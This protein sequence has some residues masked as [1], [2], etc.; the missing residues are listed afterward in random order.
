MPQ[1]PPSAPSNIKVISFIIALSFVCALVLA[2]LAS[3]LKE[4]QEIAR[5]LDRSKQ[6]LM[7]ARIINPSGFFQVE[8]GNEFV[9]AKLEA[10]KTLIP[11]KVPEYP[12]RGDLFDVYRERL[13]PM[14][15]KKESG[16]L[17]TFEKAG[18][19]EQEYVN[20]NRERGYYTLPYMLIYEILPNPT[21]SGKQGET[22]VGYVIPINGYGLW[23]AI[24]GY[25]AIR[26]DGDTVIGISW[27]EQKETPGLG[28]VITEPGWQEQFHGKKIFQPSPDGA[29]DFQTAPLG[30]TVIKGKVSEV[31][32]DRP[33]AK[34]SI[35]GIPGAT[36][37]G[38]GVTEAFQK[39]LAPYRPF[40]LKLHQQYEKTAESGDAK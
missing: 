2:V 37:T 22:P 5:D 8:E 26:P 24:Y 6:M 27:Y 3:A 15:V 1:S 7:A 28:A 4:P 34:S 16:E 21:D 33:R 25:L 18:I 36:L 9:A 20:K 30:L 19:N 17:V 35:D 32:G 39:T 11:A 40:L 29:T 38:N 31:M 14:L 10:G 23:D 12:D 13:R